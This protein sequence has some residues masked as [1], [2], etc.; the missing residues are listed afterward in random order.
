MGRKSVFAA[1][2]IFSLHMG[3]NDASAT[4]H[5]MQVEQIIGGVGGDTSAQAVQ[6]RMLAAGQNLLNGQA[7][8]RVRDATGSNPVTIT[9]FPPPN[10]ASGGCVR[11]LIASPNF[12][13]YT[14]PPV[15]A[16]TRDYVMTNLIPPSY[17]AAGSLTFEDTIGTVYWRVSWGGA[18][19]TGSNAGSPTNVTGGGSSFGPP[20]AGALPSATAQALRYNPNCPPGTSNGNAN[21]Y[22]VT[23]G[24]ATFMNNDSTSF[25]VALPPVP[26][27]SQWGMLAM[28]LSVLVGATLLMRQRSAGLELRA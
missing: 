3:V 26:T 19:Y 23:A 17:L 7:V 9:S 13:N 21:D 2:L 11:I 4:F 20:F 25:L 10:P 28:A 1:T 6:L 12:A 22:T 8:L 14:T 18:G 27:V 24:A 15:D 16:S 5:F